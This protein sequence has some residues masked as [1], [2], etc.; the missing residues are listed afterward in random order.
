MIDLLPSVSPRLI[1]ILL[2]DDDEGDVLLTTKALKQGKVV[3]SMHVARDGVEAMDFLHRVGPFDDAPR[4]DLILLDLNM[5]RKDGRETLTEIKNDAQL[6]TIPV[7][8]LTTS[9]S[10][11][12][13]AMMYNLHANCFVTKPVDLG[14]FIRMVQEIK[15]FWFTI[16]KLPPE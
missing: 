11:R 13:V 8:I 15:E 4:P 3:N 10:E 9:D 6:R 5:P 14:Q 7:V 12:D 2:V 1:D 16:V